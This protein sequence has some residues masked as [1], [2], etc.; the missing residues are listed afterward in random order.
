MSFDTHLLD[1][2]LVQRYHRLEN[3]RRDL[4]AQTLAALN[5][6]SCSYGIRCA[7][8]FGSVVS[9]HR[10]HETSDVDIAIETSRPAVLTEAIGC[11]SALLERDVDLVD[12]A[13]VPFADRIRRKGVLWMPKRMTRVYP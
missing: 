6:L 10:F 2:A 8:I 3:E 5:V 9:P 4:L 13:T 1:E 7:Y 11:F 12:L